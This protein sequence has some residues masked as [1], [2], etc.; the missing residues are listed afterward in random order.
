VVVDED[1]EVVVAEACLAATLLPAV[2]P[3]A[4][5]SRD[6][7]E[8]LVVLVDERPGCSRT[9]RTGTPDSRSAS[10]RRE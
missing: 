3:M 5:A 7:S 1:L 8:L 9:Y 10:R 2:D 4:A 6:A